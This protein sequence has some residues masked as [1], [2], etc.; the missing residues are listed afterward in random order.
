[1]FVTILLGYPFRTLLG[2]QQV[3]PLVRHCIEI[4]GG[5]LLTYFCFGL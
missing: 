2:A 5:L 1:M 3:G 4:A